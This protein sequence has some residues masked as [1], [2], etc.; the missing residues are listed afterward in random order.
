MTLQ[1]D[2][3]TPDSP[4]EQPARAPARSATPGRLV[5]LCVKELREILRDRRTIF[6]L[7]LMP[8]LVY[9]LLSMA[10]QKFTLSSISAL[11]ENEV[12]YHVGVLSERDGLLL[13]RFLLEGESILAGSESE[14]ANDASPFPTIV[15]SR[16]RHTMMQ[17]MDHQ[18][19][20]AS[21]EIDIVVVVR[22]SKPLPGQ[23]GFPRQFRCELLY[24]EETTFGKAAV[25]YIEK[26]LDAVN[27]RYLDNSPNVMLPAKIDITPIEGS[28]GAA[29]SLTTLVPLI[30]ILMTI[31]G[32][33]YPAIDLTAG[34]R[35]RGTL[36]TLMAAPVPRLRLLMA[37][38]V[39]VLT[40]ALF[41]ATANL[42]AM[43]VTLVATGL[44]TAVFGADGLSLTL[45]AQVFALLILFATFFSAVLLAVT[46]FA[47]S[48][49]E[50]QAYLI[51]LMLL[52]LAPGMMSLIPN[53]EFNG[54][55]AV[56]PLVNI[57][58]L[59]RDIF[60]GEVKTTLATAAVI[61]SG[62]YAFAAIGLAARVFG[63]DAIL[64]GSQS[65]WL[66]LVRRPATERDSATLPGAMFCL[67]ALFP[68][69]F[70]I[71]N[72][73]NRIE[74]VSMTAR[75]SMSALVTVFLFAALPIV[76][77]SFQRVRFRSGFQLQTARISSFA[78]AFVLGLSLWPL[79]HE[80]F[81]LNE[82]LGIKALDEQLVK[83]VQQFL[84]SWKSVSPIVVLLTLAVTPAVCEEFFFRGY[85][86]GAM[87]RSMT[88]WKAIVASAV[89][90]GVFHVITTSAL[91]TERFLPSTF[92]GLVLGWVCYRTRSVLPG[93]LLH[94]CHN[95]LLLMAAYYQ[96][97]LGQLG[98]GIEE[99]VHLPPLWLAL[100]AVGVILGALLIFAG[101]RRAV[102]GSHGS[103]S[104]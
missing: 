47:R 74:G 40:V 61:S 18:K 87:R 44:G 35:E 85:L 10:F 1:L 96:E 62:L 3:A 29:F 73:L 6:T 64:Y 101:T 21:G 65:S 66:D 38:Y 46:S 100:A 16:L 45:I 33:V 42:V 34:E 98:F 48:F 102:A 79:A 54:L 28:A 97:Q 68:L 26:R 41:T 72:T 4:P 75:F 32:A 2:D 82:A 70:L 8:L 60:E 49:K 93:M 12:P 81:L 30:L 56:T 24:R 103:T 58:L 37:K 51:P 36:E 92:M 52:S 27:Q 76:I 89:L 50:A 22:D 55:L 53:L 39:A 83:A 11:T 71:S 20:L 94:A 5:R 104:T 17:V 99:R 59:A 91:S 67:A 9:P 95:G 43:T 69:Y 31:T 13:H 25:E 19:A 77:A 23:Q 57:V 7:V 88:A 86:M 80:V 63:T 84:A 78:A 14:P 15:N 90:F